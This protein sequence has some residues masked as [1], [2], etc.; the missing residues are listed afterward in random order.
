MR[1]ILVDD[2]GGDCDNYGDY[3]CYDSGDGTR[4]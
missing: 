2:D 3:T 1:M 4:W